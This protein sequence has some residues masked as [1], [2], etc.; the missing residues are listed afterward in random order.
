MINFSQLNEIQILMFGLILLRMT[1]FIVSCAV[2][3]SASISIYVKILFSILLT[4]IVY[5]T[6]ATNEALVRLHEQEGDL[7]L[8][9]ARE[10]LVGISLGF[11]TRLFFFAISMGG[12]LVSVSMGLGQ[13]QVFNPMM[14]SMGNAMEQFYGVI[15]TLIFLTLNGHHL[16]IQGI[17]QS[18][19]VTQ[20]A[21]LQFHFQ[22]FS[23]IVLKA[24]E[25]FILGIK[26]A[27]PIL[28]SMIVVQVGIALLSRAVP[29]INV[30]VTSASLTTLLGFVIIFVSLPLLVTQMI[31]LMNL[32]GVE[33]FNFLKTL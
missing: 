20:V 16:V 24:Q 1:A 27:A 32:T 19:S 7:L 22:S 29:Q 8:L 31:D 6:V 26:I 4:I 17:V 28:I 18:F 15:A 9:S 25:F 10:I 23:E 12:E 21:Q 5:K 2:F 3:S 14:G 13:A 30:L 11:V 33:F